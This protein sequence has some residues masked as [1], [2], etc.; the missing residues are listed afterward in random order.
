M[1]HPMTLS[2]RSWLQMLGAAAL[3]PS[4]QLGARQA[5][6]TVEMVGDTGEAA[7]YWARWRGPSGQGI[8]SGSGYPDRWS[9]R[10]NVLWKSPVPGSG[11][12]SPIV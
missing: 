11:N 7:R 10:E 12:S 8:V 3:L 4:S 1:S 6:S 9:D 2:R 5:A